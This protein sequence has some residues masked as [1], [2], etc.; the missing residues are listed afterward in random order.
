LGPSGRA[1]AHAAAAPDAPWPEWLAERTA[2]ELEAY[3]ARPEALAFQE[4][5]PA[6]PLLLVPGLVERVP[7][8]ADFGAAGG[9][10]R[11]LIWARTRASP[12]R[13]EGQGPVFAAVAQAQA[14]ARAVAVA[15]KDPAVY[16]LIGR[17]RLAR[18]EKSEADKSFAKALSLDPADGE[19]LLYAAYLHASDDPSGAIAFLERYLQENPGSPDALIHI[20]QLQESRRDFVAAEAT[21]QLARYPGFRPQAGKLVQRVRSEYPLALY[22]GRKYRQ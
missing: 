21:G 2:A 16:V 8:I 9:A 19:A 17:V 20:A 4:L 5:M 1:A 11:A 15:E 14:A 10:D 18:G 12:F 6:D 3:L 22:R 7:G 13:E